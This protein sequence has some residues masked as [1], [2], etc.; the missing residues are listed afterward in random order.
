MRAAKLRLDAH[1]VAGDEISG[2]DI[3]F[4]TELPDN[5]LV[6][7]AVTRE[8]LSE[9]VGPLYLALALDTQGDL[10]FR[11]VSRDDLD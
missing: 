10:T 6:A 1:F 3:V 8:Q 2:G 4:F 7:R 11:E 5:V 9:I